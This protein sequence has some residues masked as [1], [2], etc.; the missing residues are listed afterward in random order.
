MADSLVRETPRGRLTSTAQHTGSSRSHSNI[1]QKARRPETGCGGGSSLPG[2]CC[3]PTLQR[4]RGARS[5]REGY[6][7]ARGSKH[8]FLQPIGF[9]HLFRAV[10]DQSASN[11]GEGGLPSPARRTEVLLCSHQWRGYQKPLLPGGVGVAVQFPPIDQ[12]GSICPSRDARP[13]VSPIGN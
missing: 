5:A 11:I 10:G 13:T 1:S 12:K 3:V 2:D 4:E 7:A 6:L 8:F 9:F